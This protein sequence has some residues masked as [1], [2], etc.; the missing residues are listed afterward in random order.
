MTI[1]IGWHA[2]HSWQI[3]NQLSLEILFLSLL[4]SVDLSQR[5]TLEATISLNISPSYS[6]SLIL[7]TTVSFQFSTKLTSFKHSSNASHLSISKTLTQIRKAADCVC[8]VLS[9]GNEM[10]NVNISNSHSLFSLKRNW[11]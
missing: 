8:F 7:T 4:F 1:Y 6:F 2:T 11:N 10:S 3:F 5:S 9:L